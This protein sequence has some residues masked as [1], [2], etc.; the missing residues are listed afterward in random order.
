MFKLGAVRGLR[1]LVAWERAE[2]CAAAELKVFVE[3]GVCGE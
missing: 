3:K 2:M 1:W